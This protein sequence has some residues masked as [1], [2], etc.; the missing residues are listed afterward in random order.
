M[1][2]FQIVF[3]QIKESA[4]AA[5]Y[6][7]YLNKVRTLLSTLGITIGIF[8]IIAVLAVVESFETSLHQS[9]ESLGN[10]VIFVE[11][12][13]WTFGPGYKWWKY[14]NRPNASLDEMKTIS[15]KASLADAEMLTIDIGT[16]TLKNGSNS[17]TG[18]DV[19]GVTHDYYLVRNFNIVN[20]RYFTENESDNG[21]NVCLIGYNLAESLF[22]NIN[23]IDKTVKISGINFTIIG[24]F[25]K[26]GESL[27]GN[28]LDNVTIIPVNATARFVRINSDMANSKIH[29]K[30]G[31]AGLAAL[32][33]EVYGIMRNKRKLKPGQEEN[34]ALNKTTLITQ[35]L[36]QTFATVNIAGW[37]IGIFAM[38]VGGFG[39]AN[40]MFVSV[41]ERTNQIGIQKSLG[42]K[43][44]FI[45]IEFLIEAIIL[46]LLG[47]AMGLLLVWGII[48]ILGSAFDFVFYL[49]FKNIVIGVCTSI[50]IGVISGFLPALSA[51]RLNPVDAIRSK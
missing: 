26:E 2:N 37:I 35:Q 8:C 44:Y 42:A 40:I 17:A 1:K 36:D 29:V 14:M 49:S 9:V 30:A 15:Q 6:T 13:P 38:L 19:Q 50:L 46:C 20:G 41:K 16:K 27:I 28:S 12:W 31:Q 48:A 25:E 32:E 7:M 21:N 24:I 39:I 23:A 4:I 34:F 5:F 18:I 51:S 47:C 33:Q 10:D 43:N 45:L 3:T 11:K 22:P